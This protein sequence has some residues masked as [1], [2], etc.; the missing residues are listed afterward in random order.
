MREN[1]RKRELKTTSADFIEAEKYFCRKFLDK[2]EKF[3]LSYP[4]L[5]EKMRLEKP[6]LLASRAYG[7][8]QGVRANGITREIAIKMAAALQLKSDKKF[9]SA[10]DVLY[11]EFEV[12]E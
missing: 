4:K 10:I 2:K 9:M 3:N 7:L 12:I 1:T 6:E 5:G 11:P 8:T